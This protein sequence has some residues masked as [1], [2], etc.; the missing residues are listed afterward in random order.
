MDGPK[1]LEVI[2]IYRK[3][4]TEMGIQARFFQKE[5]PSDRNKL[6]ETIEKYRARFEK[7]GV[8]ASDFPE[9]EIPTSIE[10]I[11]AH[12]CGMLAKMLVFIS[13]GRIEKTLRWIGFILGCEQSS[14]LS[15]EEILAFCHSVL[16]KMEGLV[17][18]GCLDEAFVWLGFV[19]GCLWSIGQY[20][21]EEL[22]NHNRPTKEAHS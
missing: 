6:T 15:K 9:K 20:S 21:L 7:M 1:I 10:K 12:C 18:E 4:F 11:M 3:H 5:V 8:E 13:E 16:D 2:D 19:Q 17:K 22:Q 14:R